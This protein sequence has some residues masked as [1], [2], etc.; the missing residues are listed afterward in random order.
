MIRGRTA[1]IGSMIAAGALAACGMV[2]ANPTTASAS[3]CTGASDVSTETYSS[4]GGQLTVLTGKLNS[5]DAEELLQIKKGA[6]DVTSAATKFLS[7][8]NVYAG[9]ASSIADTVASFSATKFEQCV[10]KGT[11]VTLTDANGITADCAAL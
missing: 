9:A 7:K 8:K 5:C 6:A 4:Y 2:G 11:G 1:R 3:G 10:S